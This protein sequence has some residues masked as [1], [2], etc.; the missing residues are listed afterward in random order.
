M[1]L[2]TE[3]EIDRRLPVWEE[4]SNLFLDTDYL[5]IVGPE[6]V[7]AKLSAGGFSREELWCILRDEITPAFAFNLREIAGEWAGWPS[8]EVKTRVVKVMRWPHW[9]RRL[10]SLGFR[11]AI[12]RDWNRI[13]PHL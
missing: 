2:L 1:N 3:A 7:A 12:R 13:A 9:R 5:E 4:L 10:A 11:F 6:R 8:N